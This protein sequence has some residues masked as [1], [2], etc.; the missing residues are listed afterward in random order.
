MSTSQ[1]DTDRD[2]QIFTNL[3]SSE[4]AFLTGQPNT[5]QTLRD[6]LEHGLSQSTSAN[7]GQIV[8]TC[9][10]GDVMRH[11]ENVKDLVAGAAF[12]P[13]ELS[14]AHERLD[15]L[16]TTLVLSLPENLRFSAMNIKPD[17]SIF[18]MA[19][20][21]ATIF[22]HMAAIDCSTHQ[23]WAREVVSVSQQRCRNAAEEI[24]LM[25]K[26]SAHL[27]PAKVR[28]RASGRAPFC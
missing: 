9:I 23:V 28:S 20:H 19:I 16:L 27:N 17:V 21:A 2:A 22:I 12:E 8:M 10:M 5:S 13:A 3:P 7:A 25:T 4:E 26:V 14:R 6:A 1:F 18:V 11:R 15:H 24:V